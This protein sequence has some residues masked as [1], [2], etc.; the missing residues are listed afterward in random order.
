V[1]LEAN[2]T[3]ILSCAEALKAG[4]LVAFPTETVYGLGADATNSSAVEKIYR[5]KG[6]DSSNPLIIHLP[7]YQ[8]VI[9]RFSDSL[10]SRLKNILEKLS[11]F[12][13][14]PLSIVLPKAVE[15]S[16][17]ATARGQTMA[18][19]VPEH[20]VALELLAAC[21]LPIAAPS[22][23]KSLL[24][25]PTTAQHVYDSFQDPDLK[26]L[27]GGPC[28]VGLESTV[29]DITTEPL[30]ILRPGAISAEQISEASGLI[31]VVSNKVSDRSPGQM[32]LHYAPKIPLIF[33]DQLQKEIERN[34][35]AIILFSEDQI[36]LWQQKAAIV[37]CLS[38]EFSFEQIAQ[39]LYAKLREIETKNVKLIA[40]ERCPE[41]G[42][43]L[44]IMDRLKRATTTH[45]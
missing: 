17:L 34:E 42:L 19:R 6:R 32:Q 27:D 10:D 7:S 23:N 5:S 28:S 13:P 21:K 33:I 26:I 12:W 43:G 35:L 11:I 16:E 1:I 31:C 22:A 45:I 3:N 30:T 2:H 14:G 37:E 4:E 29:L 18:I 36:H 41:N 9:D 15:I 39:N 25:S 44:A 20:S 24:L 8:D 38:R 40:I